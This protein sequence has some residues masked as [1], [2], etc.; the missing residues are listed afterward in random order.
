MR[1]D[2]IEIRMPTEGEERAAKACLEEHT[3]KAGG[4]AFQ[5]EPFSVLAVG[6]DR[7]IG[8]LIGRVFWNWLWP[9]LIWV[10]TPLRGTGIGRSIL[11]KAEE[12][13]RERDLTGIYLWTQSWE[14]AGF[15]RHLGFEQFVE[16]EDFSPGHRRLGFRK[17]LI[18]PPV[19]KG[20]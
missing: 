17:Y 16:F 9:D 19:S 2:R 7:V 13:A 4:V 10:E 8:G 3:I 20:S 6:N 5:E 12:A 14:A 15:Y 1:I 11:H 18:N